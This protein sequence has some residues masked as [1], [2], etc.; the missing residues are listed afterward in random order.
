MYDYKLIER[1]NTNTTDALTKHSD[2]LTGPLHISV[3]L[4]KKVVRK[5]SQ[6]GYKCKLYNYRSCQDIQE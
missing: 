3:Y 1:K 6:N 4:N 5:T 2:K